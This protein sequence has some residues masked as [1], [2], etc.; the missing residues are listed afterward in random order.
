MTYRVRNIAIAV[1]LALVAA[2]LTLFYITNYKRTVQQG[3]S[4]VHVW[5]AA[6]DVAAGKSG[7]ELTKTHAFKEVEVAKRSVVPGA[8]SSTDQVARL[9]LSQPVFAGEQVTLRRFTDVQAQ[10]IRAQLKG[11]M[12]AVQVP[13]DANQLLAGTLK[14]GDHIDVVGNVK[15]SNLAGVTN[16]VAATRIVLRDIDV[17]QVGSAP[18]AAK[19]DP[20]AQGSVV[21]AV[22][23]TQVQ[24]LYWVMRN[25]EW[26]FELRPVVD[27]A[28]SSERMENLNSVLLDGMSNAQWQHFIQGARN[29]R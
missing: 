11:T 28:D 5:V 29:F 25:A 21:L 12:R 14:P 15:I 26:T 23:D 8:I 17:L 19:V 22:T 9:V 13:G 1:G 16:G 3:E 7:A 24:K 10:G 4:Q 6:R 18:G 27:A 20:N 2:M